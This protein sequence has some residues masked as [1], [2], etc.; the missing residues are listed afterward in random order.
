MLGFERGRPSS[1]E[2]WQDKDRICTKEHLLTGIRDIPS[3]EKRE[4]KKVERKTQSAERSAYISV[5]LRIVGNQGNVDR[6]R[7]REVDIR[8]SSYGIF[9]I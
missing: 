3:R 4:R 6:T 1:H 5:P 9:N 8:W 7:P 2:S